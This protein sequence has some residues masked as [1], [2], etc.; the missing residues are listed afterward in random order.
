MLLIYLNN[1]SISIF[2][3]YSLENAKLISEALVNFFNVPILTSEIVNVQK[4][5]EIL[6]IFV[7]SRFFSQIYIKDFTTLD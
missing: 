6:L 7:S 4:Q 2:I 3:F 5:I 1:L